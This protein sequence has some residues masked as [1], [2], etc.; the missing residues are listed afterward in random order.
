MPNWDTSGWCQTG[1]HE[2]CP[3]TFEDLVCSCGCHKTEARIYPRWRQEFLD[4]GFFGL[5]T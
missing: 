1:E 5:Y 2:T 3:V 4:T